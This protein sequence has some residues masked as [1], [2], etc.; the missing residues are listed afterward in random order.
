MTR[1]K[2]LPRHRANGPFL[3]AFIGLLLCFTGLYGS[4]IRFGL[5]WDDPEWYMRVVGKSVFE[6]MQPSTNFQFYRPGVLNYNRLF[7]QADKTLAVYQLHWAQIC[8]YLLN[9]A[10]IFAISRRV[11]FVRWAALMVVV[12]SALHPFVYQA[13]AW[14]APG[15]PLTAVLLNTAWVLY[16]MGR[17]QAP[18]QRRPAQTVLL[19]LSVFCFFLSLTINETAVPLAAMPLLFEIVLRLKSSSWRDVIK[20]W[21]HPRQNGWVWPCL[22]V[23]FALLFIVF[24]LFAPKEPGITGFFTD[25]RVY[26]YFLQ[27]FVLPFSSSHYAQFFSNNVLLGIT[28]GLVILALWGLAVYRKRGVL[29]SVGL[30]WAFLGIAP[31]LIGLPYSYVSIASRLFY[32]AVPGVAWLWVSALWPGQKKRRTI[33][34]VLGIASLT[35]VSLFGLVTTVGFRQLYTNGVTHLN[36][37]VEALADQNGRYLFINFP[38]RYRLKEEP[39]AI[40]YWGLTLA[41]VVV[42]LAEFPALLN[43]SRA[44]TESW[45][46]PWVDGEARE[47]GPYQVDM[48]GVITQPDELYQ[49]ARQQDGI[50]VTHY[51]DAGNFELHYAGSLEKGHEAECKTAVFVDNAATI[52]LQDVRVIPDNGAFIVRTSWW[53]NASPPPHLSLFTHLGLPNQPPVAQADGDSWQDTLPLANWQPGDLIIDER[54]LIIPPGSE[55]FPVSLGIYNWVNGERLPGFDA[56]ERPLPDNIYVIP[57][58]TTPENQ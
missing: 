36:E 51:D 24:W 12:L 4:A 54:R 9:L 16:L 11:G 25:W 50:F 28:W 15:Q 30:I 33:T 32:T 40:G 46:M 41:P 48:R 13:V 10:L 3:L 44:Q 47:N 56:A 57:I 49:L 18:H 1:Q 29:A 34:A 39:L 2:T 27:G 5:I 42:D 43:G 37:V 17:K 52:C 8:W 53:T 21:R 14:A 45:S 35:F 55:N 23:I 6:L 31:G 7:V 38:D 22:Y 19:V 58:A 26:A 20:S